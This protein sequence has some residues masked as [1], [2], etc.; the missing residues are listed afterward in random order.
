MGPV[1]GAAQEKDALATPAAQSFSASIG[2]ATSG[3]LDE[4]ASPLRFS[5]RGADFALRYERER[6]SLRFSAALEGGT[7][8]LTPLDDNDG[9]TE[10]LTEA[11]LELSLLRALRGSSEFAR[12]TAAGIQF[13]ASSMLTDHAYASASVVRNDFVLAA[14]SLGPTASWEHAIAGGHLTANIGI[15]L[16]ALVDHPFSDVRDKPVPADF[17]FVSAASYRAMSGGISFSSA[18]SSALG[19]VYSYRIRVMHFDDAQPVSAVTQ[20]VSVGLVRRFAKAR[21]AKGER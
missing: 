3:R 21:V 6:A 9:S 8:S 10:Q 20:S 1:A 14:A 18:L 7:R 4:T 17:R 11:R 2:F 13:V 12:H 16:V 19:I 15:P 5:G